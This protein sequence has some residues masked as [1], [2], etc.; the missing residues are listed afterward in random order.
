MDRKYDI[1][2]QPGGNSTHR[3]TGDGTESSLRFANE[4]P[5]RAFDRID[6]K[7]SRSGRSPSV[8]HGGGPRDLK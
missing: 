5:M 4:N 3:C 2:E 7:C 8:R 6:G 1:T